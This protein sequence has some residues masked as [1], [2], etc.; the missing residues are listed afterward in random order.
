M[1]EPEV[2]QA[3]ENG[4]AD[5]NAAK[6]RQFNSRLPVELYQVIKH[7]A[8]R[9]RLSMGKL[10]EEII[11][12]YAAS[13]LEEAKAEARAKVDAAQHDSAVLEGITVE[14]LNHGLQRRPTR[15]HRAS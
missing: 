12:E 11:R 10:V 13:R 4:Q 15:R 7:I 1:G 3:D 14:S 5:D 6:T 9:R 2:D 8:S